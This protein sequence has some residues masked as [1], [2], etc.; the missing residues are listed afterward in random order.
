MYNGVNVLTE[1]AGENPNSFGRNLF[2]EMFDGRNDMLVTDN[3]RQP[4]TSTRTPIPV[5]DVKFIK[6]NFFYHNKSRE[7]FQNY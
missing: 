5:T 2:N 4:A 6:R 7:N 1:T 3:G